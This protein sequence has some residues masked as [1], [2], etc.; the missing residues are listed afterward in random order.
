MPDPDSP[1]PVPIDTEQSAIAAD[2]QALEYDESAANERYQPRK[3]QRWSMALG[4]I[5]LIVGAGFGWRWWHSRTSDAPNAAAAGQPQ[6]VPVKLSTIETAT[7][8]ES[9]EFVGALEAQ[10]SVVLKPEIDGRVSQIFVAEGDRVPAGKPLV[11]LSREKRQAELAGVLQAVNAARATR[12]NAASQ[13]K[14]LEAERASRVAE[15]ELQQENLRR[16]STLVQQGALPRAQLDQVTR[17]IRAAQAALNASNQGIQAAQA[18]LSEAQAGVRQAEANAN[19]SNEEL[20][21][22]T[23]VAPIAGVVGLIPVKLGDYVRSGDT[24]ATVTQNQALDL[25]L[26]IPLERGPDIRLGQRVEG[27]D[28]QG[29]VLG[30]GQISFISPRVTSNSQSIQAKA[31]FDNSQGQLRD[32]QFI[33]ANL[34]WQ[35]RPGVLIPTSAISRLGGATFVFVAQTQQPQPGQ[36][37]PPGQP[38]LVAKQ[39]PVKLGAI[40]KNNYQVL[41]GLQ[42]GEKVIVSGLQNLSDGAPILPESK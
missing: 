41:E 32:G 35:E 15:V 3:K 2:G 17:D 16:T 7:V 12:A 18:S 8:Q 13:I 4:I 5:L 42:P 31:S 34:I 9:S 23:I 37:E 22:A 30:T 6:G 33:K 27:K 29:K 40:Q 36:P 24:I 25:R 19:L 20:K 1:S 39:K 14:A 21:D 26:S 11:Q 10:R 28:S 38:K